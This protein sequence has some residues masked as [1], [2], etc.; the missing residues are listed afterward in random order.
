MEFNE[1]KEVW[2]AQDSKPL[3]QIDKNVLQVRIANKMDT[4]LHFTSISEW[5]LILINFI[6]A[7]VMILLHPFRTGVNLFIYLE[8]VWM[9]GIVVYLVISCIQRIK[10]SRRFDRSVAGDLDH[11]LFLARYQVRIAQIIRWNFLPMGVIL[12][13]SGWEA[14]KLVSVSTVILLS[15]SLAFYVTTKGYQVN[16][17]RV[18]ELQA[19]KEKLETEM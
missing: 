18:A 10:A 7:I 13:L 2:D 1:L 14:G 3:Y 4:L 17:K 6:T 19:L 16:R 12:I 11:T 15:F 9:I 5:T 8:A